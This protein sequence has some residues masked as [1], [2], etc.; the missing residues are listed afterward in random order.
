M[1]RKRE[2]EEVTDI[3]K[4]FTET[5]LRV[6]EATSHTSHVRLEMDG[7]T[8]GVLHIFDGKQHIEI[9]LGHNTL[10]CLKTV[11]AGMC[12]EFKERGEKVKK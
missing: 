10:R 4:C 1:S 5:K 3:A 2:G 12:N 9:R 7:I 11:L 8:S 6:G